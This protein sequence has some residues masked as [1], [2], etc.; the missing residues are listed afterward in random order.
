MTTP[1]PTPPS[2]AD[3]LSLVELA[4]SAA[5]AYERADLAGR[6]DAAAHRLRQAAFHVLVVGEFKQGKSSLINALLNAPVCTV[7]DDIATAVPTLVRHAE[8]PAAAVVWEAPRP[9]GDAEAPEPERTTV[10]V[11]QARHL[12]TAAADPDGRPVT[13]V[14]IALPRRLLADGLVL[15]DTPGVGGLG[16]T[17]TAT[18]IGALPMADAV[19]F[20]TDASQELAATELEF[21][22]TA[23]DFCPHV[24]L[25]LTKTD[26]YPQWRRIAELNAGHLADAGLDLTVLAVS[27]ALREAA[28]AKGDK[29]MNQ[30]SGFTEL[31]HLLSQ[32]IGQR[33]ER[34]VVQSAGREV[35]AVAEQIRSQ[36]E[37]ERGVLTDPETAAAVVVELEGAKDRADQLRSQLARWQQTLGDGVQDLMSEVDFD[38]RQRFRIVL[39]QGD[40]AIEAGDPIKLWPEFEPWLYRRIAEDVTGNYRFL[41]QR[42]AELA[43]RVAEHFELDESGAAIDLGIANPTEA[44]A[45]VEVDAQTELKAM[46]VGAQALSGV[47]GGYMGSLMFTMLGGMAGLALGPVAIGA[48]VLLGRKALKDDKDRAL[49][50]RRQSAKNAVRKY[51]DEV[52]FIMGDDSRTT[53]RRVQRQ[54]RDHFTARAEELQRSTSEN[55][56]AA[57][58]AAQVDQ[59]DRSQRL[60]DVDAELERLRELGRRADT[61]I[62]AVS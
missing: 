51:T 61:L 49:Q 59:A 60:R 6:L 8:E 3:A 44:M 38:L 43:D 25:V 32:E 15:V 13:Q 41:H 20:V 9:E 26:F 62:G 7:D 55:L 33:G 50:Q 53:L 14:E 10:S 24:H 37:S 48:G 18:T 57:Q 17:H 34:L 2:R 36:F 42:A 12:V 28:V 11:E 54:L 45:A 39:R 29:E 4:S 16:S 58:Q 21:L 56:A 5:T 52:S 47:R 22:R 27:S 46:S 30:E 1:S 35:A 40:E 23:L 19:L 31:V